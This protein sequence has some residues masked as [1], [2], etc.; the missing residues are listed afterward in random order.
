MRPGCA[1][2]TFRG[3]Y[4]AARWLPAGCASP[5]RPQFGWLGKARHKVYPLYRRAGAD[6]GTLAASLLTHQGTPPRPPSSSCGW[7][8]ARAASSHVPRRIPVHTYATAPARDPERYHSPANQRVPALWPGAGVCRLRSRAVAARSCAAARGHPASQ[9]C[10]HLRREPLPRRPWR[11]SCFPVS[12]PVPRLPMLPTCAIRRMAGRPGFRPPRPSLAARSVFTC[13]KLPD[14][15]PSPAGRCRLVPWQQAAR[16]DDGGALPGRVSK[17]RPKWASAISTQPRPP[18]LLPKAV[19]AIKTELDGQAAGPCDPVF[20]SPHYR[21]SLVR[22]FPAWCAKIS[23]RSPYRLHRR[24]H[25]RCRPRDRAPPCPVASPPPRCPA[26]VQLHLFHFDLDELPPNPSAWH[27]LIDP[28]REPA[29]PTFFPRAVQL[30]HQQLIGG[31]D[32][33][34]P[35]PK[36][37]G[38][39]SGGRGAGSNALFP[40]SEMIRD[41]VVGLAL[42]G[43]VVIDTWSPKA[44]APSAPRSSSPAARTTSFG[45]RRQPALTVLRNYLTPG[46]P[47]SGAVPQLAV[48]RHPDEGRYH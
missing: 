35:A 5:L 43:G 31:L 26:G 16:R 40:D 24:R 47:R 13:L 30:R 18:P 33:A 42:T 22:V 19:A 39:A 44:V 10:A 20:A 45:A 3:R 11:G 12:S 7:R 15:N 2:S 37:G 6:P 9:R 14:E 34:Y 25:H 48:P 29:F 28:R 36:V 17:P 23:R 41:G 8:A 27:R 4:P 1:V 38:V 21:D 32:A 46:R